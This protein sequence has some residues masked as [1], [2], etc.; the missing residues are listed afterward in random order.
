[1]RSAP[2][3]ALEDALGL[4]RALGALGGA[5]APVARRLLQVRR[6]GAS[7]AAARGG[8]QAGW[9]GLR[10]ACSSRL[11]AGLAHSPLTARPPPP[12]SPTWVPHSVDI[13]PVS[14][15]SPAPPTHLPNTTPPRTQDLTVC[16]AH[17][18][19]ADVA[20]QP[21]AQPHAQASAARRLAQLWL[22]L[23]SVEERCARAG[24]VSRAASLPAGMVTSRCRAL[25]RQRPAP[26]P[27]R[28]PPAPAD[29]AL[30][31]PAPQPGAV[32]GGRHAPARGV[33]R[34]RARA[35]LRGAGPLPW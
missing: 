25:A 8:K 24:K 29:S 27:Q 33:E 22:Q 21:A 16:L 11:D 23:T 30:A 4:A 12:S 1:M 10:Q 9:R 5:Y 20:L 32:P 28:P 18:Q 14:T 15:S 34:L 17:P 6:R 13:T 19:Y 31:G 7:R 26:L 35:V 2:V 3:L